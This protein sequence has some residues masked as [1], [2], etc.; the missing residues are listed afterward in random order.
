MTALITGTK[1]V[2]FCPRVTVNSVNLVTF[3]YASMAT[4]DYVSIFVANIDSTD[5]LTIRTA[6]VMGMGL[7]T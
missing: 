3:G 5:N 6:Q 1:I 4:N 2:G 7:V